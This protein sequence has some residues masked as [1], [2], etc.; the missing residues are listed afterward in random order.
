[1]IPS[2]ILLA[3]ALL[4]SITRLYTRCRPKCLLR[5]DDYTLVFALLL[6]IVWYAIV[7]TLYSYGRGVVGYAQPASIVG[8]LGATCG[9]L[10]FWS[11][12]MVRISMCLMIL[13]LKDS[14]RWKYPLWSLIAVQIG[15][16]ISATSINLAY[17]R[18]LSAA[19][20]PNPD[21][22]CLEPWQMEVFAYTY[23]AFNIASDLILSLIPLAFIVKMHRRMREKILIG[24]LMAA[25]LLASVFGVLRFLTILTQFQDRNMAWSQTKTD[26]LCGLEVMVAIIAASLP[27]L[28]APTERTLRHF[29]LLHSSTNIDAS[30]QS[31]L[32][33]MAFG[34]HIRRQ[35]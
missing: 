28:K 2:S 31:F 15:M 17:C 16:I 19:W 24:C 33:E 7:A 23:N 26:I 4:T 20:E 14:R 5:W 21:A 25:G 10:W 35:I 27:C 22:V 32:D 30:P 18:P 11:M 12:N 29:G 9:V 3:L 1:L 13:P 8:P 6:L 34:D